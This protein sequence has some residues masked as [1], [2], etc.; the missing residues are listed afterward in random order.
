MKTICPLC[1]KEYSDPPALS[2]ADN[3]TLICPR[4]G[5]KEALIA[6][7]LFMPEKIEE[8]LDA[9]YSHDLQKKE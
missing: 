9:M 2:R 4:C 7:G 5:S 3:Q 8:I 1:H 6:C